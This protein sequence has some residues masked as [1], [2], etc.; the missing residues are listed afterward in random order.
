MIPDLR[1]GVRGASEEPEVDGIFIAPDGDFGMFI[2]T[3]LPERGESAAQFT[4]QRS[5]ELIEKAVGEPIDVQILEVAPWQPHEQVADQFCC[6]RVFLTGDAA[7]AMPC[8]R[9]AAPTP[10]SKAPGQ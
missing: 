7:H 1:D 2:T 3:H 8:S 10:P 6:G 5:R 9:P 4:P